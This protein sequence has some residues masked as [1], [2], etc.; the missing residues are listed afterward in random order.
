MKPI[1]EIVERYGWVC[2]LLVVAFTLAQT[3]LFDVD[4]ANPDYFYHMRL[5][6]E[7]NYAREPFLSGTIALGSPIAALIG[8]KVFIW[9]LWAWGMNLLICGIPFFALGCKKKSAFVAALTLCVME[10]RF[11]LEPPKFVYLFYVI[12]ITSF[13]AYHRSQKFAHVLIISIMCALIGFVRFPSIFIWPVIAFAFLLG[14]RPILH[15]I[16]I[17]ALPILLFISLVSCTNGS[18]IQYCDD[19][20]VY[21]KESASESHATHLIFLSEVKTTVLACI[22]T[23]FMI[24]PFVSTRFIKLH[25]VSER[26]VKILCTIPIIA[27][28]LIHPTPHHSFALVITVVMLGWIANGWE[29]NSVVMGL[30]IIIGAMFCSVGS[31][32]GFIHDYYSVSFIPFLIYNSDGLVGGEANLKKVCKDFKQ[33]LFPIVIIMLL[34]DIMSLAKEFEKEYNYEGKIVF[35]DGNVVSEKMKGVFV[36]QRTADRLCSL[37]KEYNLYSKDNN[38]VIFWGR[39]SHW[40]SFINDKMPV[41]NMWE[42]TSANNDGKSFKDFRAYIEAHSPVVIDTEKHPNTKEFLLAHKYRAIEKSNCTIFMR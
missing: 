4:Y 19:I 37:Q 11:G 31:D 10:G 22:Y 41:T 2:L 27:I 15:R 16:T 35:V 9:R 17:F 20:R 8:D 7:G 12:V 40:M 33:I 13:I 42:I 23:A 29:K 14:K 5:V 26:T 38:D 30:T 18:F 24:L 1:A 6:A 32:C 21:M 34:A 3:V 36:S 25:G 28:L 39:A